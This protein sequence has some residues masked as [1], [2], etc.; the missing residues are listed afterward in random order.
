MMNIIRRFVMDE[1][2]ATV[3]ILASLAPVESIDWDAEL[4]RR[5]T[6][7]Q[8]VSEEKER[9]GLVARATLTRAANDFI[10]ERKCP[11]GSPGVTVIAG[12]PWFADWGRDTMISLPGLFLTTGRFKE[13]AQVLTL[14]ASYVSEGMIPNK[15]DDYTNEPQY[16]TVDA[17][18]WFIH[19][20]F[21]Y[22]RASADAHTFDKHLLPACRAIVD[23]CSGNSRKP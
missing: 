8:P 22:V 23:A 1:G 2:G 6:G 5:G 14:F 11:D 21:E 17:S 10:V 19:A 7:Y 12:Y 15:F 18:L 13:A 20:C 16:N 9:H 3:T 4:H